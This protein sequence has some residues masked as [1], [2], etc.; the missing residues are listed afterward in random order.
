MSFT[1]ES[2]SKKQEGLKS[3]KNISKIPPTIGLNIAKINKPQGEFLFWDVGGQKSLRK[4]WGKYFSECHGVVFI[5]DG[6][7]QGRFQEV[8]EVIDE[9]YTRK[10]LDEAGL[11]VVS[12]KNR[13]IKRGPGPMS[14]ALQGDDD[15]EGAGGAL[16]DEE[17]QTLFE[18]LKGLPVLFLLNKNDKTEFK[19][20]DQ[21]G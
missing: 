7:D 4:I 17:G 13:I 19:G 10:Q 15:L 2:S 5:I 20:V 9:L 3:V 18:I 8:R 6:A 11:P 1:P 16:D 14:T 21:I 12:K